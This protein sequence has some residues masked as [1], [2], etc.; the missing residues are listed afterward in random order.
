MPL[1]LSGALVLPQASCRRCERTINREIETRL[2][3][4]EWGHFRAKYGLPTRRPKS[5]AKTVSLGCRT[6]GRIKVPANEYTAPVPLY[7]FDTAR[8]LS[9]SQPIPNSEAWTIA[10]LSDGDEE[11][12]GVG[13]QNDLI[14]QRGVGEVN[15]EEFEISHTKDE[16]NWDGFEEE[17]VEEGLLDICRPFMETARRSRRGQVVDHGPTEVHVDAAVQSLERELAT[18]EFLEALELEETLPPPEQIEA[19]NRHVVENAATVSPTFAVSLTDMTIRVYIDTIGSPNDPYF[20]NKDIDGA[21]L[22]IVVNKQHPHWQML[23]GEN[24]ITNYLRHCV[25]DGVAEHRATRLNRVGSD[26]VKRL[27]DI[28]LRVP[29]EVLQGDGEPDEE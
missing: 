21:T 17:L 29:F 6:G 26:S 28:Y 23:E 13:G 15:L 8:I 18:P 27:K 24:S 25:Y 16:I 2:L 7:R 4:E 14:N 19:S 5:R 3:S 10:V 12:F 22:A 11:V 1:A 9:G 20:V